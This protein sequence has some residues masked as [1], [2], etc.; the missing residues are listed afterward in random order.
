MMAV[1]PFHALYAAGFFG[2]ALP[3]SSHLPWPSPGDTRLGSRLAP[4][5]ETLTTRQASLDVADRWFAPSYRGLDPAL[6]TPGGSPRT[7]AGCYE[8]ILA[9]PSTGLAPASR[10]ELAGRKLPPLV[11]I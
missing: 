2:A 5:G 3:S 9:P 8:G 11:V 1:P 4:C 6:T 10:R 7:T